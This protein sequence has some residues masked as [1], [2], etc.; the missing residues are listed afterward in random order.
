MASTV[1][2]GNAFRD[3]VERVLIVAG[4]RTEPEV[5]TDFKKSDI[6][7]VWSY[8]ALRGPER[9]LFETKAIEGNL[10]KSECLE[11][12]AEYGALIRKGEAERAWLISKGPVS[13]DARALVQA[14]PNL[15]CWTF[16]ELQ[17]RLLLLDGY[18]RALGK[19]RKNERLEEYYIRPETIAGADL[20]TYVR[21]WIATDRAAPLFVIGAYGKGKSTFATHLAAELA[22]EALED[23]TKRVPILIHLGE[24]VDEQSIDGLL[25]KVLA[26]R[27][28]V[29]NYHFETFRELNAL[30]R[31]LII[32]DGLDEMKHGMTPFKLANVMDELMRL[33][34]GDARILLL[35]RDTTFHSQAEFRSIVEGESLTAA[36]N[37]IPRLGRR[38]YKTVEIRDF[39]V[40]EAHRYVRRYLPLYF[41]EIRE[42]SATP[43]AE[44]WLQ[45]RV[46]YLLSGEFDELL[47]RP[48]HAQMLCQIGA[49]PQFNLTALSVHALFDSFVHYLLDREVR[50]A[51]RDP[52]FNIDA[53]RRFNA[54]VAWWLWERGAVSATSLHDVPLAIC[55]E[56]ASNMTHD[57]DDVVL[58]RELMQGC[59]IEKAADTIYFGHRSLQ[60]FLVADHLVATNLLAAAP[61]S[62]QV[63]DKIVDNITP[64]IVDFIVAGVM[65]TA[66]GRARAHTWLSRSADLV[67]RS[68]RL[69]GFNLFVKLASA[70]EEPSLDPL[71]SP[72]FIWRDFFQ[73]VG[74]TGFTL[75]DTAMDALQ[76]QVD[77]FGA[78]SSRVQA[79]VV[80][81]VARTLG[82]ADNPSQTDLARLIAL[83]IDG[84]AVRRAVDMFRNNRRTT[85]ISSQSFFL[86]A[87]LKATKVEEV[88]EE[89]RIGIHAAT[90]L[91]LAE[92]VTKVGFERVVLRDAY[93]T[94]RVCDLLATPALTRLSDE[95][96]R[97]VEALLLHPPTRWGI[98]PA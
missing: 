89:P 82:E 90:L 8:D 23:S 97:A 54:A 29:S 69:Q 61:R 45:Q 80:Y 44:D 37:R 58:K 32:Y 94:I 86:W 4:F 95:E 27:H 30:G 14:D 49:H 77:R 93:Q 59:L 28:R 25:G 20:E 19:E 10:P 3:L 13:P 74:K 34:E 48:V 55:H 15:V 18:L 70:L 72:W 98:T 51:G 53:R 5:R 63:L 33:D 41:G 26:S 47:V 96:R 42:T 17:R 60:E 39:N 2:D 68:V 67:G 73:R 1:Q 91:E 85:R 83:L 56:A 52:R 9:F 81:G 43:L 21:Q 64:E 11:F 79:T 38:A 35:G 92:D 66:A 7:G 16:A 65:A 40:E 50:K 76:D 71:Q 22:A 36:G 31:F 24:I 46:S 12:V 84:A 88:G 87:F 75:S 62:D 6:R 78:G 57:L